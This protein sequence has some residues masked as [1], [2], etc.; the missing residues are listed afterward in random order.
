M[1]NIGDTFNKPCIKDGVRR[2]HLHVVMTK[3]HFIVWDGVSVEV[4]IIV[5]ATTKYPLTKFDPSCEL[6]QGDHVLITHDS[7]I[8]YKYAV[9]IRTSEIQ[10]G[11]NRQIF[12]P[13]DMASVTLMNKI[14][15]G[16]RKT[17]EILPKV[18]N[19]YFNA[20]QNGFV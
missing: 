8:I 10:E 11:L 9:T 12:V 20:T 7:Y 17:K 18:K 19:A 13:S 2:N 6:A 5:N 1:V 14:I 15:S 16:F 4:V 3:P